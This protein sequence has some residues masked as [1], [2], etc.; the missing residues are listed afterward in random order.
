MFTPHA[1]KIGWTQ[2]SIG[3]IPAGFSACLTKT[4]KKTYGSHSGTSDIDE[5][6]YAYQHPQHERRQRH[7]QCIYIRH[8]GR[9]PSAANCQLDMQIAP[10]QVNSRV[11]H[12]LTRATDIQGAYQRL[13]GL[14]WATDF[15]ILGCRS[16]WWT[17]NFVDAVPPA[18]EQNFM[19]I[20]RNLCYLKDDCAMRP[21][22]G[23]PENFRDSLTTPT[24]TIPD[25]FHRLL[26]RSTPWLVLQNLKSV[27]LPVTEIRE[28]AKLQTP[29]SRGRGGHRESG[30]YRSKERW[31]VPIGPQ[32]LHSNFS[33]IRDI[34][35][36]F[37]RTPFPYPPLI[38]SPKFPHV[39]LGVDGS[40][41]GCRDRKCW[42]NSLCN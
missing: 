4:V 3:T 25:I 1:R 38:V 30:W 12:P 27:V 24:A 36:L 40:P 7:R 34:A 18:W 42:A 5:H 2:I 11:Y 29:Q 39:P 17:P 6:L 14:N 32:C 20:T 16:P 8:V 28:V 35:V 22:H 10:S 21:I 41:L 15:Y 9:P 19:L 23:C 33:S 26:F 37:S 31:W 13:W